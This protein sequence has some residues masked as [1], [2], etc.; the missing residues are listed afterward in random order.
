MCIR[1]QLNKA[2]SISILLVD[3]GVK[4]AELT[5]SIS[6]QLIAYL[7]SGNSL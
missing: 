4:R 1:C 6:G 5:A 3:F 7:Q 2:V